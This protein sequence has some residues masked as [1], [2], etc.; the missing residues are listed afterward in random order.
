MKKALSEQVGRSKVM[1]EIVDN[2]ITIAKWNEL[3]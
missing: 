2:K 3:G 1:E